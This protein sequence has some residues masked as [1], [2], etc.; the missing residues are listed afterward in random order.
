MK[1]H[2]KLWINAEEGARAPY[3]PRGNNL[4]NAIWR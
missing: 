3:M 2:E 1:I 4:G